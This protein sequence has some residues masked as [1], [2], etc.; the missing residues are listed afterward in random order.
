MV[1]G[2]PASAPRAGIDY[3][4]RVITVQAAT[5]EAQFLGAAE[6]KFCFKLQ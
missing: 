1:R 3:D 6:S 2:Y 5:C 4:T